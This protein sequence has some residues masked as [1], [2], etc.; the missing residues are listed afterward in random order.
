[1]KLGTDDIIT[2]V[3][4]DWWRWFGHVSRIHQRR[5]VNC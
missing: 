4:Q 5:E 3:Q 1:V 2:M